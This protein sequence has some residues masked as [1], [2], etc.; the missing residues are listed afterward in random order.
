MVA[1]C[2]KLQRAE[3]D[4]S[5]LGS[6]ALP[7][8]NEKCTG[9]LSLRITSDELRERNAKHSRTIIVEDFNIGLMFVVMLLIFNS[10]HSALAKLIAQ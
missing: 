1:T 10:P 5:A 2:C 3:C 8:L 6:E 9:V 4:E 7:S